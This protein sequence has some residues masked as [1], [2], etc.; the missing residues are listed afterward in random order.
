MPVGPETCFRIASVSKQFTC[1]AILMLEAEGRL[2]RDDLV[3]DHLPDMT[4]PTATLPLR[5]L[6]HNASGV[7]DMFGILQ[8]GGADLAQPMLGGDADG[9]DRP[10]ADAELPAGQPV[11]VQQLELPAAGA[12]SSRPCRARH[13]GR[14]WSAG[15]SRRW[16]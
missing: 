2:S 5:L 15:S 1:A 13:W 10:A 3:G 9:R 8:H 6:M 7:R 12:H 16:A 4:E 11:S 14:S